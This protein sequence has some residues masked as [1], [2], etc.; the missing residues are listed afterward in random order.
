MTKLS[1]RYFCS[2]KHP[3]VKWYSRAYCTRRTENAVNI[4]CSVLEIIQ[5]EQHAL[6]FDP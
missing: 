5:E 2:E 6:C 4:A 1:F 3:V